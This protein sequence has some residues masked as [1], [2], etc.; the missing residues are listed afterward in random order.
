VLNR[1]ESDFRDPAE[2][3][4]SAE[5]VYVSDEE[6]GIRR[7]S[8][9][10]SF[11]YVDAKGDK[12]GEGAAVERIRSLAIPPAW[13]DVWISPDPDGHI[14]ATGRDAKGRKQYRYHDRWA[15]CRDDVK[16]TTLIAFAEA[17]PSLR[18]M[19]DKDLSR[20]GLPR[21]RVV[22]SVIWLLDNT[23]IRIGNPAYARDNHSFGLTTLKDR[24]VEVAGSSLRFAFKGKS[25]K[26]W[27]LKLVDRRMA[28]IVRGAQELPGQH[29][30]QYLDDEGMRRAVRSEDVNRYIQESIGAEFSSKHFRTWG[31][32]VHAATLLALT[33]VPETQSGRKRALNRMIDEVASRLGNTRAVCRSCYVH[34]RVF[35]AWNEDR[36][37]G[38]MLEA[39]RSFR[40]IPEGFD[41]EEMLVLRW[42]QQQAKA[43]RRD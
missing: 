42:L 40:K 8:A 32:T 6:P 15:L 13:T 35:E 31:G 33:P 20:R 38:E 1:V 23:M 16:F 30:F 17:L 29:L 22:A 11:F 36:L 3:A 7:K 18:A 34:P 25:G 24:H 2:M 43:A 14:Q 39:R 12:L 27:R 41:E 26:E 28:R 21:E 4:A 19:I 10:R 9:G 5:L 37:A